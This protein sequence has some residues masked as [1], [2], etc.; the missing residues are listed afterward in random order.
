MK[1]NKKTYA[2]YAL[3][4]AA[5][6]VLPLFI[7]SRYVMTLAD[8]VLIFVVAVLGLNYITGLSGENNM[9]MAGIF[10]IG[11]YTSAIFTQR[12]GLSPFLGMLLAIV[13]GLLIG[14]LLGRP[15]LRVRGIYLALTTMMFGEVVRLLINN[16][17]DLT[18]GSTGMRNI[19]RFVVFGTELKMEQQQYYIYLAVCILAIVISNFVVGGRW[20]REF[21]AIRD[22]VDGVES[23]GIHVSRVKITAFSLCAVFGCLGGAMYA[24]LMG[25]ITPTVFDSDF[26]VKFF[27]M[28]MLGGIGSVPGAIF[29]AFVVVMLPEALR[30][31]GDYYWLIFSIIMLLFILFCPY[32]IAS[33]FA[34]VRQWIYGR[35]HSTEKGV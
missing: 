17:V 9:G 30:F 5:L 25:Y 3:L 13:V 26:M 21:Q 20:G 8:Q 18:G 33:L 32:G 11:A 24:H 28:L 22:N 19:P 16:L 7:A 23:C 27:M 34:K 2:L 6:L 29:G 35:K 15:S 14:Q 12:T 1:R 4:L 10:A 31:L